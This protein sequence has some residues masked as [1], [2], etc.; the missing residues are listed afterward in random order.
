MPEPLQGRSKVF[1]LCVTKFV[2]LL[3]FSYCRICIPFGLLVPVTCLWSPTAEYGPFPANCSHHTLTIHLGGRGLSSILPCH[4]IQLT[5]K[6]WSIDSL[7]PLFTRTYG[8]RSDNTIIIVVDGQRLLWIKCNLHRS[9]ITEHHSRS[10]WIRQA[11]PNSHVP[12]YR[13]SL[14]RS[15]LSSIQVSLSSWVK[16]HRA[17]PL[18]VTLHTFHLTPQVYSPD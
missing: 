5:T 7:A 17:P 1:F 8:Y 2:L 15:S 13:A 9:P 4:L 6:W 11:F 14:P 12:K 18:T 16:N 3:C 10:D